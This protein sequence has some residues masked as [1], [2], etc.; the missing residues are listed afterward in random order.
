M[1]IQITLT[2]LQTILN[3]TPPIVII[4]VFGLVGW[5]LSGARSAISAVVCLVLIG[6]IG[7]W[8]AAMT[9]LA[10]VLTAILV[11]IGIGI[12]I[13]V[14]A[15]FSDRF[16]NVIRIILDFM[17]SV[18]SFV[19]L[20]PIVMLFGIGNVPG[21]IVTV[22]YA[23][24]PVVRLTNLGLRQVRPD[25]LEAAKAF[26]FSSARVLFRIQFPLATPTI[27]AGVNQTVM[28][29][30]SM[31]V[32]GAMISVGGLGQM[33]LS[34]I[35]QLDMRQAATGGAGIVLLAITIDRLSQGVAL[36]SRERG[37]K[38]WNE[39]GPV[40]AACSMAGGLRRLASPSR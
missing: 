13:G 8:S 23:I 10:I 30:L 3:T 19:Y 26:G 6:C 21:V 17:Q 34:G 14:A 40:G 16:G 36:S 15:S 25:A 1:P 12:P 27:M 28:L 37:L 39:R 31:A 29:A 18:P 20:I 9:T 32:V 35:G 7:A 22:I 11:A 38:A 2:W 4:S 24:S 5:Q 33:V